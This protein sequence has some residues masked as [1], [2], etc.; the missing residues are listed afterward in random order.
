MLQTRLPINSPNS[1]CYRSILE[2]TINAKRK[3]PQLLV[4]GTHP[5]LMII[6]HACLVPGLLPSPQLRR[7]HPPPKIDLARQKPASR[8]N[9]GHSQSS[10]AHKAQNLPMVLSKPPR[11][12]GESEIKASTGSQLAR[13]DRVKAG[14]ALRKPPTRPN[15]QLPL[16]PIASTSAQAKPQGPPLQSSSS[17]YFNYSANCI[18]SNLSYRPPRHCSAESRW[19]E[20]SSHGNKGRKPI[21]NQESTAIRSIDSLAPNCKRICL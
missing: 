21:H 5:P 8:H 20:T 17:M 18:I 11:L 16:E 7:A 10:L 3:R 1:A 4:S 9:A 19:R 14:L 2:E 13:V 6:T 12:D 15:S